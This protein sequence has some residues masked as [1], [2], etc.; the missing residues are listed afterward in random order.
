MLNDQLNHPR[1]SSTDDVECF[2]SMVR[3]AIGRNFTTKEVKFEICKVFTE[4]AKRVDPDL[5]F[6]YHTSSHTRYYEGPLP[7]F[8]QPSRRNQK[9]EGL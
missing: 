3:D 9:K 6:Y 1:A 5:P 7:Q 2:F 8:D 4:F